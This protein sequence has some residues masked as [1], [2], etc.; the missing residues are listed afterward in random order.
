M[1]RL[2]S[3]RLSHETYSP[4]TP[5]GKISKQVKQYKLNDKQFK[6]THTYQVALITIKGVKHHNVE[7]KIDWEPLVIKQKSY[8]VLRINLSK[9]GRSIFDQPML[10]ITNK[11]VKTAKDASQ[12]YY[13]YLLRAKI[14]VVFRFLKQNLGWEDFQVRDF[15]S[16]KNL[17]AIAFFLVGYFPE[18][19]EELKKHHLALKLCKLA[20]SKGKITIHF[21]LEGLKIL[22]HHQMVEQWMKENDIQPDEIQELVRMLTGIETS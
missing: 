15:N 11:E 16:I 6:Y 4:L 3:N 22:T 8:T 17:L 10:L 5:T 7:V 20:K 14:E 21:L 9:N 13:A 12:I 2:K 18:L 1:T 19:E